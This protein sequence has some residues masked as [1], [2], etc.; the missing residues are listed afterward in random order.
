MALTAASDKVI[1]A[2]RPYVEMLKLFS[3]N[4]A[5]DGAQ[6]YGAVAVQV[7]SATAGDFGSANGYNVGTGLKPAT[8]TL[9]KHKKATFQITDV[10]AIKDDLNPCWAQF[11]PVAGKAVAKA[12]VTDAI[13]L[14]T[15]GNAAAQKTVTKASFANI[16]AWRAAVEE[17]NLDPADCVLLLEPSTFATLISTIPASVIGDGDP[18]KSGKVAELLGF[19]AVLESPNVSKE[20]ASG[21]NKGIGF[22]VPTGAIGIAA[23]TVP[24]I[25][26]VAGGLVEYGIIQDDETGC[27]FDQRVVVDANLGTCN[28]T[29]ESLYGVALTKDSTNGA[30]GYLQLITA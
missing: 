7:L 18:V 12:M 4:F 6:P 17:A 24:A 27:S 28:W 9:N 3:T 22:V 5:P 30:P 2:S 8:V 10:E 14:L 15:Y 23:R 25:K 1:L 26:G 16:A 19:K 11:A 20:S 21:V 13:A 29:V